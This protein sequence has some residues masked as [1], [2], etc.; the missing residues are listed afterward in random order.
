MSKKL[1]SGRI[2]KALRGAFPGCYVRKIHVSEFAAAGMPGLICCV[3]GRFFAIEV[4]MPGETY[5]ALANELMEIHRAGGVGIVGSE[6]GPIIEL[7][8]MHLAGL[9]DQEDVKFATIVSNEA[10]ELG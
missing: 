4:K 2:Q 3:N 9:I 6:P 10:H 5:T 8:K 1:E 7:I